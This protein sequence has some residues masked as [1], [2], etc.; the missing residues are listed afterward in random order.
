MKFVKGEI[1]KHHPLKETYTLN[2]VDLDTDLF[3]ERLLVGTKEQF[4]ALHEHVAN[5][6][7]IGLSTPALQMCNKLATSGKKARSFQSMVDQ[8]MPLDEVYLALSPCGKHILIYL[9]RECSLGWVVVS[10]SIYDGFNF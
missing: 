1:W 3:I 10:W 7:S 5:G 4:E 2:K 6:G 9:M 8:F